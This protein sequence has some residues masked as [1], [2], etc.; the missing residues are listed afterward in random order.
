MEWQTTTS[1]LLFRFYRMEVI[2]VLPFFK[3]NVSAK[4]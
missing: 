2:V 1:P 3:N 4:N